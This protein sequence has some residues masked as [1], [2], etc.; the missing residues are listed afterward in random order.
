[1]TDT[2][3]ATTT[4]ERTVHIAARPELVWSF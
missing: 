1:V 3:T 4:I 2:P